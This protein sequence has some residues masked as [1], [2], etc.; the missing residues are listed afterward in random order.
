MIFVFHL[1][2]TSNHFHP[3]Q[4]ENCDSNSR[5]VVDED[6]N[7]KFRLERV[8]ITIIIIIFTPQKSIYTPSSDLSNVL[9]ILL[10]PRAQCQRNFIFFRSCECDPSGSVG[11]DCGQSLGECACK[12]NVNGLK[13]DSCA[14]DSFNLDSS[15]PDGCQP[16]F[17]YGH[18]TRCASAP[19]YVLSSVSS[20]RLVQLLTAFSTEILTLR[21]VVVLISLFI[22]VLATT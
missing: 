9:A 7:D 15:N 1:P 10:T 14:V 12:A 5:L 13:C 22:S 8:S 16:C 21:S 3:L 19:G 11:F 18:S 6:D 20:D 4:V 17:C 2:P